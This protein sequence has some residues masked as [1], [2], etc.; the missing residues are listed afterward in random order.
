MPLNGFDMTGYDERGSLFP[1]SGSLP[2]LPWPQ[3]DA[4]EHRGYRGP[5]V[6]VWN[7]WWHGF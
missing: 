7:F 2:R 1:L 5:A 4:P 6:S 3:T